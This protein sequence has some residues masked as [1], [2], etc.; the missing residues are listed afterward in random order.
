MK[1]I[2]KL[3]TQPSILVA[4]KKMT[5]L[6]LVI[7]KYKIISGKRREFGGSSVILLIERTIV[8]A[9]H[10]NIISAIAKLN[11][12]LLVYMSLKVYLYSPQKD[13]HQ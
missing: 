11:N 7:T 5:A 6:Q 4:L 9:V 2:D 1:K 8:S 3:Y 12:V 13:G 10:S